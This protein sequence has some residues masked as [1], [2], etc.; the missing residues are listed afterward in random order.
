MKNVKSYCFEALASD[1]EQLK[2]MDGLT[3][4]W[5]AKYADNTVQGLLQKDGDLSDQTYKTWVCE[6]FTTEYNYRKSAAT[7]M[8]SYGTQVFECGTITHDND[9]PEAKLHTDNVVDFTKTY[10]FPDE[11]QDDGKELAPHPRKK[12][13]TEEKK[14]EKKED[15]KEE[16]KDEVEDKKVELAPPVD[17]VTTKS[18]TLSVDQLSDQV[19]MTTLS[20]VKTEK[21][22]E[23]KKKVKA[24]A[25]ELG[26]KPKDPGN[27]GGDRTKKK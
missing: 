11:D 27:R 19:K 23:R 5:Y 22:V 16:K 18:S 7:R 6:S 25:L 3:F 13:V 21:K 20:E 17:E 15:K 2:N 10:V 9:D 14:E 24:L 12:R 1:E 4:I 8:V 26:I